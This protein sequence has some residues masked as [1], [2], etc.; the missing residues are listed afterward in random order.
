MSRATEG[1]SATTTFMTGPLRQKEHVHGQLLGNQLVEVLVLLRP[2]G[3]DHYD[4]NR[5]AR[6]RLLS[7][8]VPFLPY[9]LRIAFVDHEFGIVVFD[10][11]ESNAVIGPVDQKVDLSSCIGF[12]SRS[13]RE[14]GFGRVD[15]PG[16][17]A[18]F[19]SEPRASDRC[20]RTYSLPKR[21]TKG[22]RAWRASILAASGQ[23]HCVGPGGPTS[24]RRGNTRRRAYR[25]LHEPSCRTARSRK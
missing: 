19:L 10:L 2:V 6:S 24:G 18:P 11:T 21:S 17:R 16:C 15:A 25:R 12:P 9:L 1:F 22:R 14:R 3:R 13:I 7:E 23:R 8:N 4:E 5:F 20:L